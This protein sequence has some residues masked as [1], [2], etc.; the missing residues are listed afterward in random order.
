MTEINDFLNKYKSYNE[1]TKLYK[2]GYTVV[3]LIN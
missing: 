2:Y 3:Y 1:A